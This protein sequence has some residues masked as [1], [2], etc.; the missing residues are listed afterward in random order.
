MVG[1]RLPDG[2]RVV[3]DRRVRRLAGADG[4]AALLG[5]SPGR[6]LHLAPAAV[7]LLDGRRE[8]QVDGATSARLC[9]HLLDA[10]IGHPLPDPDLGPPE[11]E[12]TVVVPVKDRPDELRRL[13]V[14]L[15][16]TTNVLGGV[17]VVDDGSGDPAACRAVAEEHGARLIRHDNS[18]GPAS[19]RNTGAAA[20]HT[21]LVAFLD[22]DVV[23]QPGWLAPLLGHLADRAVMLAAPRIVALPGNGAQ[24]WLARYE[25]VRSSLDL[26]PDPG[27]IVP[28]TRVAYVPSAALLI[29]TEVALFDEDMHVAEDVDLVLRLHAAGW[30]MRYEPSALVAHEHRVAAVGWWMRKAFYGTGAA[31][32][33]LRHPGSVP[34]AVVA[35]WMA[36]TCLLIAS[37]R[38]YGVLGAA[39]LTGVAWFRMRRTL[40]RLRRPGTTATLLT[41]LG[42]HSALSQAAGL[43][44]RHWW[45]LTVIGCLFSRRLRRATL[46]ASVAEA[47]V[48]R[49][50]HDPSRLDPLRYL[51][52]HR[53]DDLAY[54][55][56]LWYGAL[57][58]RTLAP[59]RPMFTKKKP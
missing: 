11:S 43:L 41:G 6:L 39:A 20:A 49:H 3:L 24:S 37:Q 13:L 40:I 36:A 35:P 52:A 9:R 58:N 59:L 22:S 56:G 42:L 27:S 10:G 25:R 7:R 53:A 17:I 26:G 15:A 46:V 32:L 29:R 12:V 14:A 28:R 16:D 21:E 8:L 44:L 34:P 18:R 5:L 30:R 57:R 51:V 38:R 55:A 54:G 50:N 45:P 31:P 48:D 2:F 1:E 33:A 23:P 19:A 47:L 4:G